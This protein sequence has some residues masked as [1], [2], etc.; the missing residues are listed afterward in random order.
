MIRK[1]KT[2]FIILTMTS[3]LLLLVTTVAGMNIISY[4]AVVNEADEILNFMSQNKGRFPETDK[5]H[6][7]K[8]PHDFSPETPYESRF[9]SVLTDK[10]GNVIKTEVDRIE[11]VNE[12]D[13]AIYAKSAFI[14][15]CDSGFENNFRYLKTA[16]GDFVR[17][18]FLDCRKSLDNFKNFLTASILMSTVGYVI[19]LIAV[20]ILSG[21][22]IRPISESY[23]KQKRFITDASHE[24]KTPLT[25][26]SANI[27][28]L[29]ME[30]GENESI[31]D[32][33]HQI[34]KLRDLTD[35]LVML[36][37]ME[38]EKE[39]LTKI[40]FPIS[41]IVHDTAV[42]FQNIAGQSGKNFICNIEP[43]LSYKGDARSI[44][45]LLSILLDN[46]MKY[47]GD[48]STVT[49]DLSRNGKNILLTVSNRTEF[50]ID[51]NSLLS[52]FDRFYRQESSRNSNLGGHG[53]GLSVAKAIVDAHGGKISASTEDGH[54]FTVT[55][56]LPVN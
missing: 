49:V 45:Q 28:I 18:I 47:S 16:E 10:E 39:K 14:K 24:I 5:K 53:I 4:K 37:R 7:L 8:L 31:S 19:I 20:V 30:I 22:F 36:T 44:E 35:D 38:E 55:V 13:A 9:F 15:D 43:M 3:L 56:V 34:E 48:G 1:L 50:E 11:A 32:I 27:D 54:S 41:D 12:N 17:I 21:R 26:I 52:V 25:V 42:S 2:K 51:K 29:E 23:E 46:A 40:E 6:P 33:S